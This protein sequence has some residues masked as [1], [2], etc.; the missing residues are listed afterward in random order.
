MVGTAPAKAQRHEIGQC[1]Q[2]RGRNEGGLEETVGVLV[3]RGE[4]DWRAS[5][6]VAGHFQADSLLEKSSWGW[7]WADTQLTRTSLDGGD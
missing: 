6:A 1:L 4:P 2:R 7:G 5:L 3:W